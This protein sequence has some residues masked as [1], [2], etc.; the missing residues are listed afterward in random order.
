MKLP[1]GRP[2]D[3]IRQAWALRFGLNPLNLEQNRFP[4]SLLWQLCRCRN[5]EARRLVLGVSK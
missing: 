2:P 3:P 4:E 5:D 1:V